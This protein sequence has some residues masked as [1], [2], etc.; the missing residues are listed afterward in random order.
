V[1]FAKQAV[2][3]GEPRW[4]NLLDLDEV[5]AALLKIYQCF[6]DNRERCC[7]N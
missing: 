7:G 5:K 2:D 4:P 1:E 6:I 3:G